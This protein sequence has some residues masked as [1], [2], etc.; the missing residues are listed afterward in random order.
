MRKNTPEDLME[1]LHIATTTWYHS[2]INYK[3]MNSVVFTVQTK[4]VFKDYIF[5]LAL[6]RTKRYGCSSDSIICIASN[7]SILI[8]H[9]TPACTRGHYQALPFWCK[10]QMDLISS[11]SLLLFWKRQTFLLHIL[12][13][14][15]TLSICFVSNN[16]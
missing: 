10:S 12:L 5:C 4:T 7:V 2:S 6:S 14:Y 16:G 15:F 1:T 9:H 13:V 3:S 8:D 11:P